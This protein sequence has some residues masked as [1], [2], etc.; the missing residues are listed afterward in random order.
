[1]LRPQSPRVHILG[2][3]L[4]SC[5]GGCHVCQWPQA[6]HWRRVFSSIATFTLKTSRP[7]F[8]IPRTWPHRRH[9]YNFVCLR[10]V[11]MLPR[12]YQAQSQKDQTN[13]HCGPGPA[14]QKSHSQCNQTQAQKGENIVHI[15]KRIIPRDAL[16]LFI[17]AHF[18]SP[19]L[20]G[21]A[22][23]PQTTYAQCLPTS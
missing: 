14:E 22:C 7:S 3:V 17:S 18:L 6:R 16:P 1:M 13:C 9:L 5:S 12:S 21:T 4:T 20:G 10:R 23:F 2:P 15:Q 19:H 11:G 8:T